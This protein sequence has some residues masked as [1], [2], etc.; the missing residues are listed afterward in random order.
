MGKEIILLYNTREVGYCTNSEIDEILDV[1][2]RELDKI[3]IPVSISEVQSYICIKSEMLIRNFSRAIIDVRLK[4]VYNTIYDVE[5]LREEILSDQPLQYDCFT[6]TD[7]YSCIHSIERILSFNSL[8]ALD[9]QEVYSYI[10]IDVMSISIYNQAQSAIYY[11]NFSETDSF[12]QNQTNCD[13]HLDYIIRELSDIYQNDMRNWSRDESIYIHP[14]IGIWNKIQFDSNDSLIGV[15][16]YLTDEISFI[17][18][19]V[20][21]LIENIEYCDSAFYAFQMEDMESFDP[22]ALNAMVI[23]ELAYDVYTFDYSGMYTTGSYIELLAYMQFFLKCLKLLLTV[24][25]EGEPLYYAGDIEFSYFPYKTESHEPSHYYIPMEKTEYFDEF[26]F[27]L[28]KKYKERVRDFEK[29]FI[30]K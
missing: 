8:L 14:K 6:L 20:Q 30:T 3:L 26:L 28:S 2:E 10:D 19:Q 15:R 5:E 23:N 27:I 12:Y 16:F 22:L 21:R 13:T 4:V 7:F 29:R 18:P 1:R 25:T 24:T 11:S 17:T 9:V